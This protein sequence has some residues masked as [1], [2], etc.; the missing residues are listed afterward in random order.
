[1]AEYQKPKYGT[2]TGP[3]HN[4]HSAVPNNEQQFKDIPKIYDSAWGALIDASE[5]WAAYGV[6][7]AGGNVAFFPHNIVDE[8][9][10]RRLNNC[11]K[12]NCAGNKIEAIKFSPHDPNQ[13]AVGSKDMTIRVVNMPT[14]AS[15]DSYMEC[16]SSGKSWSADDFSF[17]TP[18]QGHTK[19]VLDID[20]HPCARGILASMAKDKCVKIWDLESEKCI[21]GDS[22]PI[23]EGVEGINSIKWNRDGTLLSCCYRNHTQGIWSIF[24]PRSMDSAMNL[25][26]IHKKKRSNGF[27]MDDGIIG[28]FTF[29][30]ANKRILEFYDSKMTD[31]AFAK[32][33]LPAGGSVILPTYDWDTKRL[34]MVGKGE[35]QF[36][37]GAFS[38][39]GFQ[40]EGTI[41][42][43]D[44]QKGGCW[45]PK[46]GCDVGKVE[47]MRLLKVMGSTTTGRIAPW[48]VIAPLRV[49]TFSKNIYPDTLSYDASMTADDYVNKNDKPPNMMSMDPKDSGVAIKKKMSYKELEAEVERLKGLL[50]ANNIA[51]DNAE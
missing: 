6:N 15:L 10:N 13:F 17:G 50:D 44:P 3:I 30:Q 33:K 29:D 25:T 9:T 49:N 40:V 38:K 32:I 34:F 27:F 43:N 24:D 18:M 23:F 46:K 22:E 5:T 19:P 31:K 2:L 7:S 28:V 37:F 42:H 12:V 39:K 51:Y 16:H 45:V 1:M 8:G 20:W 41:T 36:S 4:A 26:C 47:V 11:M 48:R 35:A 21:I 14:G